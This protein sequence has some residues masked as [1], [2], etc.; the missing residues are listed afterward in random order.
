LAG[1][2]I[3]IT[4]VLHM[5]GQNLSHHIHVHCIVT[6]GAQSLDGERW[7]V[8]NQTFL[9]PTRALSRVFRG[10]YLEA[11]EQA[12]RA[13]KLSCPDEPGLDLYDSD[14]FDTLLTQ[15]RSRDWIVYAK[16]PFAGAEKVVS[17]LGRYTHRVAISN[18]RLVAFDGKQVRF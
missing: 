15:L 3:G 14:A 13:G 2:N 11:L 8:G 7:I 10:K 18:H 16:P 4:M 12:H 5:W 9:F 6:G 17:Y 1:G